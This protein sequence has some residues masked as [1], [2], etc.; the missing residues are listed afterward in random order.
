MAMRGLRAAPVTSQ[1]PALVT[2][3]ASYTFPGPAH[4]H[5]DDDTYTRALAAYDVTHKRARAPAAPLQLLLP[6]I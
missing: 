6:F 1:A 2:A 5:D 3:S 4:R